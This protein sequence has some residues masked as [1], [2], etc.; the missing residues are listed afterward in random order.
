MQKPDQ[1][2]MVESL[3]LSYGWNMNQSLVLRHGRI[4]GKVLF[5]C[6]GIWMKSSSNNKYNAKWNGMGWKIRY[7]YFKSNQFYACKLYLWS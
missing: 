4:M 2:N 1:R 5:L 3:V 6:N 7:N